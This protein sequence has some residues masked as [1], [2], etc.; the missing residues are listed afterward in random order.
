ML[1]VA[2]EHR[3]GD[4]ML[5]AAFDSGGGLTALFSARRAAVSSSMA[6]C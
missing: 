1:S 5:D 4:F 2:V 3:L 6:P